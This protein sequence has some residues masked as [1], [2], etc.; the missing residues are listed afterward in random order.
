MKVAVNFKIIL[1][2]VAVSRETQASSVLP[3]IVLH[4]DETVL[5]DLN[6]LAMSES[7]EN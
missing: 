6:E 5:G 7:K 4:R 2:I 1:A 3:S